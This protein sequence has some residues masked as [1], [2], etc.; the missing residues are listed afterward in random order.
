MFIISINLSGIFIPCCPCIFLKSYGTKDLENNCRCLSSVHIFFIAMN[1]ERVH[2]IDFPSVEAEMVQTVWSYWIAIHW[3]PFCFAMAAGG[4]R[5]TAGPNKLIFSYEVNF[6]RHF[7]LSCL[8]WQNG[9]FTAWPCREPE[10]KWPEL[11]A[12]SSKYPKM[13]QWLQATQRTTSTTLK[14]PCKTRKSS[15]WTLSNGTNWSDSRCWNHASKEARVQVWILVDASAFFS[16]LVTCHNF[17]VHFWIVWLLRPTEKNGRSTGWDHFHT[18]PAYWKHFISHLV[19]D[20][21]FIATSHNLWILK[22][23]VVQFERGGTNLWF[24]LAKFLHSN[25]DNLRG[26][27]KSAN[28]GQGKREL[29]ANFSATLMTTLPFL[30]LSLSRLTHNTPSTS[31]LVKYTI[32]C[33]EVAVNPNSTK[34]VN[35]MESL[36]LVSNEWTLAKKMRRARNSWHAGTAWCSE[37]GSLTSQDETSSV[38]NTVMTE[39]HCI[40]CHHTKL[41]KHTLVL[42]LFARTKFL[43]FQDCN[44]F[45]GIIFCN[46][47]KSICDLAISPNFKRL[48]VCMNPRRLPNH[49]LL[50]GTETAMLSDKST[51]VLRP[52]I[53]HAFPK[54]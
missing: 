16:A 46:F 4:P 28:L 10:V 53:L 45:A 30:C 25:S 7:P 27:T 18:L 15:S 36:C 20:F 3:P 35:D 12:T 40:A 50:Y 37:I 34:G 52:L 43:R 29:I 26:E 1:T 39:N 48:V 13:K 22:S 19:I 49:G 42:L 8:R 5:P 21:F 9:L 32:G 2:N 33:L 51:L 23:L 44:D 24:F 14:K 38:L 54:K 41:D 47:M 6:F 17:T 31:R 11:V